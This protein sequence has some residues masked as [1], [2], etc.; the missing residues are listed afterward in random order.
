VAKVVDGGGTKG[1]LALLHDQLVM[2]QDL[3]DEPNMLQMLGP[4]AVVYENVKK[5]QEQINGGRR[6]ARHSSAPEMWM[7]HW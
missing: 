3:K 1:A 4:C 7:G 6:V 5:I 2:A